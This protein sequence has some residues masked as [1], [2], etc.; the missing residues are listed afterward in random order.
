M[1]LFTL[2]QQSY[3]DIIDKVESLGLVV[4]PTKELN[5]VIITGKNATWGGYENT[6]CDDESKE[7]IKWF[8]YAL[9]ESNELVTREPYDSVYYLFLINEV[10]RVSEIIKED[11]NTRQAV[12][13]FPAKHCFNSI[14]FM[15][16]KGIKGEP[17]MLVSCSMRSCNVRANLKFDMDICYYL[18]SRILN[19]LNKSNGCV[20]GIPIQVTMAVG[21]LHLFGKK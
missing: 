8:D 3:D 7:F 14:Q 17:Q 15:M 9:Y 18:A 21:S 5:N 13:Q 1:I 4:G 10:T 16:R 20:T 6:I 19:Q 2:N 11:A 12:I